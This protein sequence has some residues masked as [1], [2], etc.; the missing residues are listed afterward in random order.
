MSC[1]WPFKNGFRARSVASRRGISLRHGGK[2]CHAIMR[3]VL[4]VLLP[5]LCVGCLSLSKG[6]WPTLPF[7]DTAVSHSQD[8]NPEA[9]DTQGSNTEDKGPRSVEKGAAHEAAYSSRPEDPWAE[10]LLVDQWQVGEL[11]PMPLEG[12]QAVLQL[13]SQPRPLWQHRGFSISEVSASGSEDRTS[14]NAARAD[15][16]PADETTVDESSPAGPG[17]LSSVENTASRSDKLERLQ[18]VATRDDLAGWNA[19]ILLGQRSSVPISPEQLLRLRE[20]VLDPPRYRARDGR[21]ARPSVS[22]ELSPSESTAETARARS[23]LPFRR[24]AG[25]PDLPQSANPLPSDADPSKD[26]G[27]ILALSDKLRAAAAEA[28]CYQLSLL[29]GDAEVLYESAGRGLLEGA[30]PEQIRWELQRGIARRIPPRLIP[31]LEELFA[32]GPAGQVNTPG[33]LVGLDACITFAL[34]QPEITRRRDE[35]ESELIALDESGLDPLA[36]WPVSLWQYRWNETPDVVKR[37]GLWLGLVQHPLAESY[38]RR[39]LQH[40]EPGVQWA[41]LR[42]LGLLESPALREELRNLA[43]E[44]EGTPRAVALLASWSGEDEVVHAYRADTSSVVRMAVAR[45]AGERRNERATQVLIELVGDQDPQV[46][47]AAVRAVESWHDAA[48]FPVL[49]NAF[50]MSAPPTRT[51]ARRSLEHRFG[52]VIASL[53]DSLVERRRVVELIAERFQLSLLTIPP[54]ERAATNENRPAETR[55]AKAVTPEETQRLAELMRQASEAN[56]PGEERKRLGQEIR[57]LLEQSPAL[58]EQDLQSRAGEE[59]NQ[60]VQLYADLEVELCRIVRQLNGQDVSRRRQAARQLADL[61]IQRPLP[62]WILRSVAEHLPREQDV[63]VCR[64]LMQSISANTSPA[65]RHVAERA[66]LHAWPD[67]RILGCQYIEQ[68]GLPQLAPF[69]LPLLQERNPSIQQA[70][71][72]AAGACRNP[73]VLDGFPQTTSRPGEIPGGM[74]GLRQL[75]GT[76]SPALE[77]EVISSMAKL[78]DAQGLSELRKR[79]HSESPDTRARAIALVGELG[80]D[81]AIHLLIRLGWTEPHTGAR[82]ALLQ[83]LEQLVPVA[84]RPDLTQAFTYEAKL[85]RWSAWAEERR[86][87]REG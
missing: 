44:K 17:A 78:G 55:G 37:F 82:S 68:Q 84:Q 23:W 35:Q 62:E 10:S 12:P 15:H 61:A 36:L 81:R 57:Q 14:E 86:P 22:E 1:L 3:G 63:H 74:T 60:R 73:L 42:S 21:R 47:L 13:R 66:L 7:S 46:Q 87:P 59:L 58:L 65:A 40:I 9:G 29:P 32:A 26:A 18:R 48:A 51:Q 64:G 27:E 76:V 19:T 72:R 33:V 34:Y 11:W 54:D 50:L 49:A 25:K 85:E 75:L 5:G 70:A 24:G 45:F 69:L 79:C 2:A 38:L 56:I 28:W 83:S 20:L 80:D 6:S 16:H 8:S 67:V 39:T 41:A 31:G 71:I 30:L 77:W 4:L 53:D 52:L 43:R